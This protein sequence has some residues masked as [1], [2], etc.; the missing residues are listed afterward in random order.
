MIRPVRRWH[1]CRGQPSRATAAVRRA[2]RAKH[3]QLDSLALAA[4]ASAT[5][6]PN[7]EIISLSAAMSHPPAI[8]PSTQNQKICTQ[9]CASLTQEWRRPYSALGAVRG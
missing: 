6:H 4:W 8:Q 7:G 5:T 9:A 3:V 1:Q 2:T